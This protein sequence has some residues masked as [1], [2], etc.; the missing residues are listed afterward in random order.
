MKLLDRLEKWFG[1]FATPR[2][3]LILIG[4]QVLVYLAMFAALGSHEEGPCLIADR[5]ALV[6]AKVLEGEWWR[7][8]TFAVVP[9]FTNV[10]WAFLGWYFFWLMGSTLEAQ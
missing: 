8:L 4:G 6:P 5:L 10:F 1:R 7:V 9:P 2:L 3:T